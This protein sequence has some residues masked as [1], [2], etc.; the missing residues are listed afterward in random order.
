MIEAVTQRL[1]SYDNGRYYAGQA[2]FYGTA[3]QADA[4]NG[5]FDQVARELVLACLHEFGLDLLKAE[6][7]KGLRHLVPL[8]KA[9]V[10]RILEHLDAQHGAYE[11]T[12]VVKP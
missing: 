11:S 7:L 8:L 2:L 1:R 10:A 3:D 9:I 4:S 12:E 6:G 5:V